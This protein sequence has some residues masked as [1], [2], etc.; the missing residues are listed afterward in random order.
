MKRILV[1]FLILMTLAIALTGCKGGMQV[2]DF[3][4]RF[5]RAVIELGNGQIIDGSVDSWI[6]YEN[7]DVVQVVVDGV[8]YLTHYDNV[9]LIA[10]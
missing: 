5:D 4:Y 9:V 8:T 7:S 2:A 1:L 6:D 10:G 3:T